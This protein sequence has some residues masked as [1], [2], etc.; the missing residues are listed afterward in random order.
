MF[1]L[2]QITSLMLTAAVLSITNN[3]MATTNAD[4]GATII[5]D[6]KLYAQ[7]NTLTERIYEI[8]R[9][10]H[11]WKPEDKIGNANRLFTSGA[12]INGSTLLKMY[13]GHDE[14]ATPDDGIIGSAVGIGNTK[15]LQDFKKGGHVG[16]KPYAASENHISIGTG[17]SATNS[18]AIGMLSSSRA[19][20]AMA[21]GD[22]SS[23]NNHNS[24]AL[25]HWSFAENAYN[26]AVGS[27]AS[28]K[29]FQ[30]YCIRNNERSWRKRKWI[31]CFR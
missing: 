3:A 9:E 28:A 24:I 16:D 25:G 19:A 4:D 21:I 22:Y 15:L 20:G 29:K 6:S 17:A 2:N 8:V 27:G 11:S 7:P 13:N 14:L 26:M 31:D 30:F 10:R 23:A 18:I 5:A 1:K 12:G